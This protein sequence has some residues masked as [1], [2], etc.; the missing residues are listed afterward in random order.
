MSFCTDGLNWWT[1]VVS[2]LSSEPFV[3]GTYPLYP[4]NNIHAVY[5]QDLF[6]FVVDGQPELTDGAFN[7]VHV[8][9]FNF[10]N[11]NANEDLQHMFL[12]T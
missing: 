7:G 10:D 1:W 5:F 12:F 9:R 4:F 2:Y 11:V 6:M 8:Y 3:A